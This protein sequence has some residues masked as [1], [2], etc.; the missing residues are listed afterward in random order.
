[1]KQKPPPQILDISDSVA[2]TRPARAVIK[3]AIAAILLPAFGL[4]IW[5]RAPFSPYLDK[6]PWLQIEDVQ[7]HSEWPL[8]TTTVRSWLP[9]LEGKN[10]LSIRPAALISLLESKPWVESVT[11]KKEY[12]SRLSIEI[13]TRRAEAVAIVKGLPFFID[14]SGALIEH[15][16]PGLLRALDLPV[17]SMEHDSDAQAWPMSHAM[18]ILSHFRLLMDPRYTMSELVL[19]AFPYFKMF[20]TQPKIEV[21]FSYDN[22]ETQLPIL[23][24]LLHRPPDILGQPQRISL[25][26]PKKAIVSQPPVK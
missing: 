17:I 22:W 14:P 20:L 12:P 13:A 4:W 24:L 7:V 25:V 5:E 10:I 18:T 19:G 21:A 15:A 3:L 23:A 16:T 26:F 2:T 1:V 8:T 9:P 11:I 6:L